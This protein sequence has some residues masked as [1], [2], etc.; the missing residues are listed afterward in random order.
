MG[1]FKLSARSPG[2]S[3]GEP[4]CLTN[5]TNG[6][7]AQ[8]LRAPAKNGNSFILNP[9]ILFPSLAVLASGDAMSAIIDPSLPRLVSVAA[10]AS[11]ALGT[12]VNRIILP[13]MR[14]IF[15]LKVW[16]LARMCQLE[17]KIVAVGEPSYR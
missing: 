12:T 5:H 17:N 7:V 8:L 9:Y 4:M 6:K 3:P 16:M 2:F 13:E 15:F 10:V 1:P 14:K 11:V